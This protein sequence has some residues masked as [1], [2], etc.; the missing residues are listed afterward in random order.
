MQLSVRRVLALLFALSLG[1]ATLTACGS[2]AAGDSP[3]GDSEPEHE[4]EPPSGEARLFHATSPTCTEGLS[5]LTKPCSFSWATEN[6]I[7]LRAKLLDEEGNPSPDHAI[8]FELSEGADLGRL[9]STTPT[10]DAEGIA[11]VELTTGESRGELKITASTRNDEV[12]DLE[13]IVNVRP[14]GGGELLVNVNYEGAYDDI[15]EIPDVDQ[16]RVS[17]FESS[18]DCDTLRSEFGVRHERNFDLSNLPTSETSRE[19]SL[20]SD[21]TATFTF[22]ESVDTGTAYSAWVQ[23]YRAAQSD[24][25]PEVEVAWGCAASS[26]ELQLGETIEVDVEVLDHAPILEEEY[27]LTHHFNLTEALP[28]SV[29]RWVGLLGLLVKSPGAFLVGCEP[30]DTKT[31]PDGTMVELCEDGGIDGIISLI[32]NSDIAK[33]I[34]PSDVVQWVE[35]I[36]NSGLA[37]EAARDAID[38]IVLEQLDDISGVAEARTITDDIISSLEHFGVRGPMRFDNRPRPTYED[39]EPVVEFS[40]EAAVQK[41]TQFAFYWRYGENCEDANDYNSCRTK[42]LDADD[43]ASGSDGLIEGQFSAK[44]TGIRSLQI[45]EHSLTFNFGDVLIGLLEHVVFPHYFS[46]EAGGD[47]VIKDVD[48][49]APK[50]V[51]TFDELLGGLLVR[52]DDIAD[53]PPIGDDDGSVNGTL[54]TAVNKLCTNLRSSLVDQLKDWIKAELKLENTRVTVAS[55]TSE[56]EQWDEDQPCT[57]HQPDSYPESWNN[58]PLPYIEQLGEKDAQCEWNASFLSDSDSSAF[59]DISGTFYGVD[60][61]ESGGGSND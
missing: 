29:E 39:G 57:L 10:T 19:E 38:S 46:A 4:T 54:E 16:T 8:D 50:G 6:S 41:W 24:D 43:F 49:E 27:Q 21:G 15:S 33:S 28:D 7:E 13:W 47:N 20:G 53:Q 56:L 40:E 61:E 17:L 22:N 3:G 31:L 9:D 14:E 23:T 34:L 59:D 37:R 55:P 25:E 44:M 5:D 2:F 11:S 32:S 58:A 18:K 26:D 35:D 48:T 51:V 45:D 42:W 36:L 52:C 60:E 12:N 30:G 1:G